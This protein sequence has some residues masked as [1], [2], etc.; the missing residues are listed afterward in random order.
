MRKTFVA[1]LVAA[2]MVVGLV[3][4]GTNVAT[5]V[6]NDHTFHDDITWM[7]ENDISRGCN[8]PQNNAYCP[9]DFVTRGQ[10][11]AFFHRY[12]NMFGGGGDG[13]GP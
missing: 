6:P 7:F 1:A 2:F 11:S 4:Y 9:E 3:A 5:D 10:M 12:H 8:P 13:Q